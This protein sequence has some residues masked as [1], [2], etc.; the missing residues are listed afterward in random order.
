MKTGSADLTDLSDG[1]QA[2][3]SVGGDGRVF[4]VDPSSSVGYTVGAVGN[5]GLRPDAS[6]LTLQ[7]AI[8]ACDNWRGD[9]IICKA[10]TQTVTTSVLFNKQGIT[11]E[12]EGAGLPLE[13]KGERFVLYGSHTDGPAATISAP[14]SIRG[15]GFCGSETAGASVEVD[16]ST[17]GFDGG[18]FY[19]LLGCRFSHWGI[20][21][22]FCLLIQGGSDGIID[23]CMFDGYDT[24]YTTA[25]IGVDDSG[26]NGV[27]ALRITNNLFLNIGSGKYCIAM[28]DSSVHFRLSLIAHNYNIGSAKLINFNSCTGDGYT[29]IADNYTG[30]ATDTSSYNAAVSDLQTAGFQFANN[31]YEES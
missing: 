31:H 17:G 16:G 14:C 6:F 24:G 23:H 7:A 13:S 29:M 10:G 20:A 25:G 11:V 1:R 18:N 8:D 15:L 5:D 9:K 28:V 21:K 3:P 4:Y 27:L 2:V 19:E 22:A 12:A 26:S 30:A